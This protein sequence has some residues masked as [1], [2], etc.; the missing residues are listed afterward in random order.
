MQRAPRLCYTGYRVDL[1]NSRGWRTCKPM[2]RFAPNT[3]ATP[4][5]CLT[6]ILQPKQIAKSLMTWALSAP[7]GASVGLSAVSWK[8]TSKPD[9]N[10]RSQPVNMPEP[11]NHS[12]G[13]PLSRPE[14]HVVNHN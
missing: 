2:P 10:P 1:L 3:T 13:T 8:G 11:S 5:S 14:K 6:A 9:E 12:V 4:G 7:G